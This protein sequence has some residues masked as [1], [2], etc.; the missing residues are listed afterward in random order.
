[1]QVVSLRQMRVWW[2]PSL[3]IAALYL[4]ASF[5]QMR[6]WWE[7]SLHIAVLYLAAS[8]RQ[9][10]VWHEPSRHDTL[11]KPVASSS[12]A[13]AVHM[14]TN[15]FAVCLQTFSAYLLVVKQRR[16]GRKELGSM[17]L[18]LQHAQVEKGIFLAHQGMEMC[19]KGSKKYV[20]FLKNFYWFVNIT[21]FLKDN[22]TFAHPK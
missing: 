12:A 10:H 15:G 20:F 6:V 16:A 22:C 14:A 21:K 5:R 11:K 1:M 3:H 18:R 19:R 4:A 7:P 8:F 17:C 13:H 2:E 9:M